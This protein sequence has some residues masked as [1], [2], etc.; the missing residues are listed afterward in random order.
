MPRAVCCA[1]QLKR[2][3]SARTGRAYGVR[4]GPTG[5]AAAHS[6]Q[7]SSIKHHATYWFVEL[8]VAAAE[9]RLYLGTAIKFMHMQ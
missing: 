1:L 7:A 9:R 5:Y 2:M 3:L 4:G 6:A 8:L